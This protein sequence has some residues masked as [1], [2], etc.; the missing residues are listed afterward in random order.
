MSNK[1]RFSFLL[2]AEDVE[3]INRLRWDD[4]SHAQTIL[5]SIHTLSLFHGS[6]GEKT[7]ICESIKSKDRLLQTELAIDPESNEAQ[8]IKSLAPAGAPKACANHEALRLIR[9]LQPS[10]QLTKEGLSVLL[11]LKKSED[12][13]VGGAYLVERA[14]YL[15]SKSSLG[16]YLE[17][18]NKQGAIRFMFM[19]QAKADRM[20]LKKVKLGDRRFHAIKVKS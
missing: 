11:H 1:E 12:S 13:I 10:E 17:A 19:T 15:C 9:S 8:F 7:S 20:K 5:R 16:K 4:E 2:T 6:E 14:K 18:L 3:A